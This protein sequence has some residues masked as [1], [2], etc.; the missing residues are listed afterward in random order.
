VGNGYITSNNQGYM[1]ELE[2]ENIGLPVITGF[3][4]KQEEMVEG[5]RL[6]E[7]DLNKL[8]TVLKIIDS[9]NVNGIT[10]KVTNINVSNKQNYTITFEEEQKTVY[11]G[12]ASD[13]ST[14][15][16]KL[17]NILI[18]EKGKSGEIFING[19]AKT[20]NPYFREKI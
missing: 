1:L 16:V 7:D 14:R 11:L 17:K 9:I 5:N 6:N 12:D 20:G 2:Q 15:I 10:E 13:I 19:D 4:T 18:E 3:C 8:E